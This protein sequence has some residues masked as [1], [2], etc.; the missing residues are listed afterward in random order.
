MKKA[1]ITGVTGQDGSYLAEFLLEKNYQVH[2]IIRR[3]SSTNLDRLNTIYK[4]EE[5]KHSNFFL[6]YADLADFSSLDNVITKIKPDEIYNLAA[7]S[8]V[9]LSFDMPEL[10]T[11]ITGLGTLRLLESIRKNNLK[12]KF[13]QASS[14]EIFGN[15]KIKPQNENTPFSPRSPYGCAKL[16]AY[17]ITK[18]YLESYNIFACNGILFNHES[19]RRG[20]NFVT[21]KITKSASMIKKGLQD[22]LFLGNLDSKRDWG[23][24]GDYVEAMWL[25]LQQENPDNYVI[26]TGEAHSV[27]E[28]LEKAFYYL[29][30]NIQWENSGIDEIG[31]NK[32]TG[33]TIIKINP[34]FFRP[35]EVDYL[36]G[37]A[38]KAKEKLKWVPKV[39]FDELVKMMVEYDFYESFRI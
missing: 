5:H 19:P 18:N 9:R 23:F 37:D 14:S 28:F 38:S 10:T 1:L 2:G 22:C 36:L 3:N 11:D 30:I 39:S 32:K 34:Y 4:S 26:S 13:Y 17:H 21:K 35:A 29:D 24:A 15:I 16:Y 31:I 6:H 25:M 12:T 33:Q 7:Q 8:D 20:E 27:R